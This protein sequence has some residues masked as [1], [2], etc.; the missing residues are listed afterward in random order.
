MKKQSTLFDHYNA[1]VKF[2]PI[3]YWDKLDDKDRSTWSTYMINRLISMNP[4]MC[5]L[6]NIT[7]K[8][9]HSLDNNLVYKL[10]ENLIPKNNR[11]YRY[12]KGNKTKIDKN[13]IELLC[14]YF[15]CSSKEVIEYLELLPDKIVKEMTNEIES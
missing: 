6:I 2:K 14:K 4:D 15:E 11:F 12:I 3:G 7:Q 10:Y 5:D 8:Y 13:K 1:V 9:T